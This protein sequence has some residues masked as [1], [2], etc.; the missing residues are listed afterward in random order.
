M[1]LTVEDG[2]GLADADALISLEYADAYHEARGNA[3]WVDEGDD[4]LKEAAIRRAS[5]F[6]TSSYA[7]KG[8]RLKQRGQSLAWP[9]YDVVDGEGLFVPPDAVP[10]EIKEATAE[11]ALRELVTP[12]SMTPDVT[13]SAAVKSETV[14]PISVEYANVSTSASASRPILTLVD[15]LV[16][17]FINSA[18][19]ASGYS[20]RAIRG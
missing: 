8:Y 20:G 3:A 2:T 9:R 11:I 5:F 19:G 10:R 18:R 13:L 15:D 6:L 14:G 1:T 4:D 12:G 7:W 17:G 16:A